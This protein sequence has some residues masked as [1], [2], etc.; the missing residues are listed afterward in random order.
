M[1]LMSSGTAK[2]VTFADGNEGG[3]ISG[4][5]LRLAAEQAQG[6]TLPAGKVGRPYQDIGKRRG[7][8]REVIT[9]FIHR[10]GLPHWALL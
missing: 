4:L 7:L 2:V 10:L 6:V 9:L 3:G 8:V 5:E 1:W